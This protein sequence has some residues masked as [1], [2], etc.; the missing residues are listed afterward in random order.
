[1]K[2]TT[3]TAKEIAYLHDTLEDCNITTKQLESE[4]MAGGV[5]EQQA[6]IISRAVQLLLVTKVH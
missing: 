6:P 2:M 3:E 4:L 1:M 5:G